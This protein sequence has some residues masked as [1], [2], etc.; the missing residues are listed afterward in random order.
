MYRILLL[1]IPVILAVNAVAVGQHSESTAEIDRFQGTWQVTDLID[2][3][4]VIPKESFKT[5]LPSGGH[6][7]IVSNTIQF[8]SPT[9]KGKTAKVFSI[10]PTIHPK[11]IV[12]SELNAPDG[13]GIY[14]FEGERLII[15]MSDP[16]TAQRPTDFSSRP[17]SKQMLLVMERTDA[18]PDAAVQPAAKP[19][20]Q[21]LPNA[22]P[23]P[24]LVPL[25]KAPA[26]APA[27][28]PTAVAARVLTD[29]E[30]KTML[31]GSWSLNDG[32]GVLQISFDPTG[33]YRT[34]REVQ[35]PN[36]FYRVFVQVPV[37]TGTWNVQKGQL[38][39]YILSSTD[40]TRINRTFYVAVRSI[41]KTDL[42][43]VDPLG[44]VGKAVKLR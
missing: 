10:D 30:V 17:G 7:Q 36:T 41:S 27:P 24:D 25:P 32:A 23:A 5:V 43:F 11:T 26:P 42:I 14:R 8:A 35:D 38:S 3:G 40:L 18:V 16:A 4:Q 13:W 31:Q 29:A 28:L 20:T 34:Y 12:V 44:R 21:P 19:A 15:C 22:A 6:A 37:A 39:L 33:S 9:A 1:S 2:N